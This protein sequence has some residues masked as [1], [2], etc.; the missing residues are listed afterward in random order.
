MLGERRT[1]AG[2]RQRKVCNRSAAH[3]PPPPAGKLLGFARCLKFVPVCF[4][5]TKKKRLR[6]LVAD[7]LD[8]AK[9]TRWFHVTVGAVL[10]ARRLRMWA[11]QTAVSPAATPTTQPVA[12]KLCEY[13]VLG[14]GLAWVSAI[15]TWISISTTV[16]GI[17][18]ARTLLVKRHILLTRWFYFHFHGYLHCRWSLKASKLCMYF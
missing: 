10:S 17:L 7:V 14:T 8:F 4:R 11:M 3:L 13:S 2:I 12:S 15:A 5:R 6:F 9:A 1:K 16:G 18:Y